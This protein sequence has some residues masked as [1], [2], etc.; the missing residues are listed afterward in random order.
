MFKNL[1]LVIKLKAHNSILPSAVESRLM[2]KR[3]IFITIL[4]PKDPRLQFP[5]FFFTFK[6]LKIFFSK[7]LLKISKVMIVTVIK[8]STN[9]LKPS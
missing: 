3:G 8:I 2:E 5:N 6:N 7:V 9:T 4:K 1:F